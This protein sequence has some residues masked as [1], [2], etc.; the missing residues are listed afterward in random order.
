MCGIV[1]IVSAWSLSDRDKSIAK[2]LLFLDIMRGMDSTGVILGD[3]IDTYANGQKFNWWRQLGL[4]NELAK[5][6]Q[7]RKDWN[8]KFNSFIGHNRKA[9]AGKVTLANAH[10]FEKGDII[11]VHNGTL[12]PADLVRLKAILD[13]KDLDALEGDTDSEIL[14]TVIN[15]V[16]IKET[17]SMV[18][19]PAAVAFYNSREN[20]TYLITNGQ[21]PMHY[22]HT[23]ADKIFFA[24]EPWMLLVGI[25]RAQNH[26]NP[27]PVKLK[28]NKLLKMY[29]RPEGNHKHSRIVLKVESEEL[30]PFVV[31]Y[32]GNANFWQTYYESNGW[33]NPAQPGDTFPV[34][35]KGTQTPPSSPPKK[36]VTLPVP[37]AK[38]LNGG[39]LKRR[40]DGTYA[41]KEAIEDAQCSHC[42]RKNL[43]I[44]TCV[45]YAEDLQLCEECEEVAKHIA[46]GGEIT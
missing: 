2:N 27:E 21:R 4:P 31:S 24:S 17:W 10:P 35:T 3:S 32:A 45:L 9:T 26:L 13:K 40:E 14:I 15:K 42:Y 25:T 39:K 44:E 1:G 7:F 12:L 38:L 8:K 19:G 5:E 6:E 11:G 18:E 30:D 29:R 43:D 37:N 41:S 36:T 23:N 22:W 46:F 34:A 16:G 28:K 33:R 20:A